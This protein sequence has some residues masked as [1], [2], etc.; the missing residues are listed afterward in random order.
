MPQATMSRRR[1]AQLAAAAGVAATLGGNAAGLGFK[2]AEKA[3]AADEVRVVKTLCR[4]CISNCGVLA[5]VQNGRV[6]RIE[7]NPEHPQSKGAMCPK[8]LSGLQ[9]LYHPNRNK[10]P[11][12]RVGERGSNEW[13]RI[14]WDEAIDTIATE[15]MKARERMGAEAVFISTGGGGNPHFYSP[16]RFAQAFGTPNVWE[17]G[18]AQCYLPRRA[19]SHLMYGAGL[20][21]NTSLADSNCDE[22]YFTDSK[23]ESLVLWG[24]A[25]SNDSPSYGG[26]AVAELRTRKEGLKT[27]VIDPRFTADASKADVWLPLRAGTDVALMLAWQRYIMTN[28]LYDKEFVTKWTNLP[29]L[30]N[31]DTMMLYRANEVIDGGS[32]DDFVIW[33][34]KTSQPQALTFPWNDQYDVAL[35]GVFEIA[36]KSVRTGFQALLDACQEWTLEKAAE[37]CWLEAD[38]IE[39]A[40]KIYTSTQSGIILGVATDQYPQSAQSALANMQLEGLMGNVE[41]PGSLLQRFGSAPGVASAG[42]QDDLGP[43][44]NF[45]SEEMQQ[46]R[47]GSSK[48]HKG[49]N[50]WNMCHIPSLWDAVLTG[51]PYK[52]SIWLDRSGN[53]HAVLGNASI[54]EK[55]VPELD[56]I[57]HSYMY[58]TAF[59]VCCADIL[60][61]ITEWLETDLVQTSLNQVWCRQQCTHLFE[62]KNEMMVWSRLAQ[63][64]GEMGHENCRKAFDPE[65]AAPNF[66]IPATEEQ[67]RNLHVQKSGMTWNEVAAKQPYEYAPLDKWRQYYVYKMTNPKTNQPMGFPTTSAS[68]LSGTGKFDIYLE[69][70]VKLGRTGAPWAKYCTGKPGEYADAKLE[71]VDTDYQPVA[72]YVE[73]DESPLDDQEYPLVMSNGRLPMYHHGTLRNIPYLREIYPVPELWVNPIDAQKYGVET[74]DWAWIES[75]RGKTRGHVLVTEGIRPGE[76]YMERFWAPELLDSKDPSQAWKVMNVNVLSRSDGPYNPEFGT[77]TLRGYQVKISKAQE[78]APEGIWTK[79]EDF[80]PWMPTFEASEAT[81]EGNE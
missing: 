62:T 17:P 44:T 81:E 45:V 40:L 71:P 41:R 5:T 73:P 10:Y 80:A 19:M 24:T 9:A 18:C 2:K 79:P 63:K 16:V 30:V 65:L 46:K 28:N 77:Y 11:L 14:T 39:E 37:I 15:M 43:L 31:P 13:E 42:V 55:I 52:P 25:P 75:R 56:L 26:R 38:K 34:K 3:Y 69:A 22:L 70:V 68:G 49:I 23:I 53:K 58:P 51:V 78:G 61:P 1:F 57:V 35:E 76:V 72:Y 59:S 29:Y 74:D 8:G 50:M 60:L 48:N 66:P 20:K 7:G 21:G 64:C 36:G 12:K 32:S 33:D 47:L 67:M 4:A 6:I 54:L 27:V